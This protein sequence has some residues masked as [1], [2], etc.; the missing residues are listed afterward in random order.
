MLIIISYLVYLFIVYNN[1]NSNSNNIMIYC[2]HHHYY[3]KVRSLLGRSPP[4]GRLEVEE[5]PDDVL[6]DGV[7]VL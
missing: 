2:Y 7:A 6:L 1:D 5:R 4:Q 3:P